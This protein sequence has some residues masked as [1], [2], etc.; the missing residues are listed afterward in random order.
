M[1]N[2]LLSILARW[3]LLPTTEIN[4]YV[5]SNDKNYHWSYNSGAEE[6]FL[7]EVK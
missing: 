3:Q 1:N 7:Q 2:G 5:I 4:V 6:V